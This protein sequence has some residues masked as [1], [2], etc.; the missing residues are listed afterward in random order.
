MLQAVALA[1]Q[2]R[3]LT[4]PNPCVGAV[5][6]KNGAVVARGWHKGAGQPHAEIDAIEDAAQCAGVVAE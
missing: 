5:L 3:W 2:A 1:G 6:V 4:R